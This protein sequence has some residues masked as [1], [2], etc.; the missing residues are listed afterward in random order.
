MKLWS[1]SGFFKIDW[2]PGK[3]SIAVPSIS[4]SL[5]SRRNCS[6]ENSYRSNRLSFSANKKMRSPCQALIHCSATG[7]QNMLPSERALSMATVLALRLL[8][9]TI[10]KGSQN[11][12][13]YDSMAHEFATRLA[14]LQPLQVLDFV[15]AA[16]DLSPRM[17][18]YCVFAFDEVCFPHLDARLLSPIHSWA[19]LSFLRGVCQHLQY[20]YRDASTHYSCART[21]FKSRSQILLRQIPPS[22]LTHRVCILLLEAHLFFSLISMTYFGQ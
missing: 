7:L 16:C 12:K 19:F 4:C 18:G 22:L 17:K 3:C 20:F 1:W 10:K 2:R 5:S 14:N 15:G 6:R 8:W 21:L 11:W 13:D 9:S